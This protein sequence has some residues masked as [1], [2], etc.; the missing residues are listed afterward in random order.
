MW[1]EINSD[2]KYALEKLAKGYKNF[3]FKR[4]GDT[5]AKVLLKDDDY[6]VLTSFNWLSFRGDPQRP[7]REE[8]GNMISI[9]HQVNEFFRQYAGRFN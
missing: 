6:F 1:K 5:H 4:L 8:L 7:F 2:C 9:P 3:K